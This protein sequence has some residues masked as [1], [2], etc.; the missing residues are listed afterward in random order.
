MENLSGKGIMEKVSFAMLHPF[1]NIGHEADMRLSCQ[2]AV[3]GDV[4][5]ETTP[6]MN[7]SGETFW[8]KPY[9]NK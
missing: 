8:Q 9:P 3:N 5:V 2:C 6:E 4:Q 7:L 1:A